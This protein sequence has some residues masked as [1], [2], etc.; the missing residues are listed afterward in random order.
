[1]EGSERHIWIIALTANVLSGERAR[2]LDAR[3]DDYRSKPI[4]QN[5]LGDTLSRVERSTSR[6]LIQL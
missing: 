4:S 3:M 6:Q 1:M 5:L 2:C